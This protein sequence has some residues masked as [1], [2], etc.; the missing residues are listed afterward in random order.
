MVTRR[1]RR[2]VEATPHHLVRSDSWGGLRSGDVVEIGGL[3]VRGA[4]WRFVA[5][6]RN[7]RNGAESVEVVGGG[8]GEHHVRS[9]LPE[10]VF[11]PGGQRRGGPS[12]A[13]APQ[14]PFG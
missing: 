1:R 2:K 9:F 11:A 12:L 13:D 3:S 4:T 7:L 8:P 14:L 6:V 10:Q 5:H